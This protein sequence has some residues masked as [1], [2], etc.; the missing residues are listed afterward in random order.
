MYY[1]QCFYHIKYEASSAKAEILNSRLKKVIKT[2]TSSDQTDDVPGRYIGESVRL[3]S[4]LLEHTDRHSISGFLL[5][6]N[7]EKVDHPFLW[8]ALKNSTLIYSVGQD[9]IM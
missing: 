7:M 5:V 8:A 3:M 6:V 1:L 2:L 4:D 9:I